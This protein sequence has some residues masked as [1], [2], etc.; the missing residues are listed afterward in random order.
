M[1]KESK[2]SE[3]SLDETF[4]AITKVLKKDCSKFIREMKGT[5]G[6]IWRG[7]LIPNEKNRSLATDLTR[8][9]SRIEKG[10]V[11]RAFPLFG[12]EVFNRLSEMIYGWRFRDGVMTT[13]KQDHA[14]EFGLP[15]IFF[16]IG[17]YKYLWHPEIED[18]N[19]Y[20]IK[21]PKY[22]QK[23]FRDSEYKDRNVENVWS[24]FLTYML[25][26]PES[27]QYIGYLQKNPHEFKRVASL[28][29]LYNFMKEYKEDSLQTAI[30]KKS[31][32][33]FNCKE[34]YLLHYYW[35]DRILDWL[36]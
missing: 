5:N 29:G 20:D 9:A 35:K 23:E 6:L 7:A 30:D 13:P 27:S 2:D 33:I 28:L 16:P 31:E 4:K 25:V 15:G 34:Y 18:F 11:P 1:D 24:W 26:N 10:R 17:D 22:A 12:H 3:K 32:I 21:V 36:S 8:K 14:R 19:M